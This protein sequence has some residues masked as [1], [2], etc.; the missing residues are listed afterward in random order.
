MVRIVEANIRE[1]LLCLSGVE[2]SGDSYEVNSSIVNDYNLLDEMRN[3]Y[4]NA[5]DVH[6][7]LIVSSTSRRNLGYCNFEGLDKLKGVVIEFGME[8]GVDAFAAYTDGCVAWYDSGNKKLIEARID[9]RVNDQL[10]ILFV[11]VDEVL[12]VAKPTLELPEPPHP[13]FA[14]ISVINYQG[15]SF[16]VGLSRDMAVDRLSAPLIKSA[17]NIRKQILSVSDAV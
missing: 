1:Y 17:L 9:V 11:A 8:N 6:S 4:L 16:G 5:N 3:A 10:E 15:I 2:A 13:G 12:K 14:M 7:K